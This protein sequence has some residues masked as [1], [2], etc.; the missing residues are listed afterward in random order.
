MLSQ[1]ARYAIR[2]MQHLADRYGEGPVQLGEIAKAQRIP[3][4]FLTTILSELGR[5]G[6]V[7]SQ[8]GRDGGY[9]L[10]TAPDALTYGDLVRMMRGSLA[11]VPCASRNA[12]ERCSNCLAE[13]ECR[14]RAL[15]LK[16]RDQT[17]E[18]LDAIRLSDVIQPLP[19]FEELLTERSSGA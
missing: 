6:V 3:A 8:R 16:V 13:D 5:S 7:D 14:L 1:K 10:A 12:H 4:N 18:L 2:A 17:A 19:S 15:M 9:W 11:L